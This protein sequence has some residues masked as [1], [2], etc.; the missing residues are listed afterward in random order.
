MPLVLSER[1]GRVALLTLNRPVSLNAINAALSNELAEAVDACVRD[2]S[3][4]AIVLTG[5]GRAFC[6][7]HDLKAIAAGESTEASRHPLWGYAGIVERPIDKPLIV[8]A[9]GYMLGA[10]LEIA[11]ACDLVIAAPDLRIGLPE[12]QRGL[13]A[14]AG[15]VAR[16]AQQLPPH[17]AAAM[18][19]TGQQMDAETALRWGLVN[20]IVA[21]RA[22]AGAG[23]GA[24][25]G[26][27]AGADSTAVVERAL[28]IA[29]VIA[30]NAPLAVQASKRLVRSLSNAS[31]WTPDAWHTMNA[32]FEHIRVTADAA[33]GAA[34][35][36]EGR[37]PRWAAR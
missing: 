37:L 25:S 30:A 36:T 33:A 35:F 31:T 10:G 9:H 18:I 1:H 17:I 16:L 23:P 19:Y 14:A 34:A 2:D 26:T 15:G 32:E 5:A 11:L 27:A 7:G 21:V 12:V 6:A 20:E 29:A 28:A 24:T 3:V 8:A 4:R 22:G 13:I